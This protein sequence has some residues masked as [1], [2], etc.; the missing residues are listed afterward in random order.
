MAPGGNFTVAP[1]GLLNDMGVGTV[2]AGQM[3]VSGTMVS[4]VA[5]FGSLFVN[6]LL[7]GSVGNVG[8][9]GGTGTIAGNVANAGI[10]APGNSIGTLTS[11]ATSPT[12]RAAPTRP[13]ST[14]P[15]R[16]T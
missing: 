16:A 10:I 1:G 3:T 14:A 15:A 8:L 5:N 6:G 2:N 13:R 7:T 9:L 4:N 12:P 11:R